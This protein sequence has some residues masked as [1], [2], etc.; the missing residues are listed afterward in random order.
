MTVVRSDETM[1]GK[2][3]VYPSCGQLPD[4]R[5]FMYNLDSV[6][7][8]W[9]LDISCV[10]H[11][12]LSQV[13]HSLQLAQACNAPWFCAWQ[14]S[15]CGQFLTA[16]FQEAG[17]GSIWAAEPSASDDLTNYIK[18]SQSQVLQ[19]LV[20]PV[21]DPSQERISVDALV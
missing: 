16:S 8:T 5:N 3:W 10:V 20:G 21:G 2:C 4:C 19:I 12:C 6:L 14:L 18:L 7:R 17:A 1:W 15:C 11:L 13:T 9:S